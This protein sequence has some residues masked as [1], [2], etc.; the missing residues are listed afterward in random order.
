MSKTISLN[1]IAHDYQRVADIKLLNF[2]FEIGGVTG[3]QGRPSK[4]DK[5]LE[6]ENYRKKVEKYIDFLLLKSLEILDKEDDTSL[7]IG[8]SDVR[9]KRNEKISVFMNR[10]VHN[11]DS[12]INGV[13]GAATVIVDN[14]KFNGM[15]I[16]GADELMVNIQFESRYDSV[17]VNKNED[18]N[19]KLISSHFSANKESTVGYKT[20]SYFAAMLLTHGEIDI[21]ND[22]VY[23]SNNALFDF[24]L[25]DI[26]FRQIKEANPKGLFRTYRRFEK[27]DDRL[28]GTID[29]SRHIRLNG[30]QN[31][32]KVAYIYKANTVNNYLNVLIL[33]AFK[34]VKKKYPGIINRKLDKETTVRDFFNTLCY[35]VNE[36][37]VSLQNAVSNN[38]K[39]ISHP[40]YKEYEAVRITCLRILRNDSIS[41]FDS[42][43]GAVNGFLYYAP[44]LWEDYLK[45]CFDVCKG[46]LYISEQS[47]KKYISNNSG[48]N[49][50][51]TSMPDFYFY[52]NEKVVLILDAKL[53]PR[54]Q[55][56]I[57]NESL[58]SR[59]YSEEFSLTEDIDKCIRDM[60]VFGANSTGVVFPMDEMEMPEQYMGT[61]KRNISEYS[62]AYFYTLPHI[63]PKSMD[64]SSYN[65]WK[66]K[67][68][69]YRKQFISMISENIFDEIINGL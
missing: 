42:T 6:N 28:K 56:I 51:C 65:E 68:N 30:G 69:I 61:I 29:I 58:F 64:Y 48:D 39:P 1:F 47:T 67:F 36:Q 18:S 20:K 8:C 49:Y 9:K 14:D 46:N 52:N 23:C 19:D 22:S 43:N 11:E 3:K 13:I 60:V 10:G 31:N 66:K 45:S 44:D 24:L 35:E 55:Y 5:Y 7:Y 26:L 41:I 33:K 57:N 25:I 27:N 38:I 2:D 34:Y 17:Y 4:I 59:K 54:W 15:S 32:G 62:N 53:K 37:E 50:L 12:R 16:S 63:I 21:I 40:F